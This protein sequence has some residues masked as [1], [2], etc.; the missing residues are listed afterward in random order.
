MIRIQ[1]FIDGKFVDA[2]EGKTLSFI[3]PAKGEIIGQCPA[4]QSTD[5]EKAIA[6]AEHANETWAGLDQRARSEF[7]YAIA[8]EIEK[9]KEE[10]GKIYKA[11]QVKLSNEYQKFSESLI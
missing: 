1:N 9:N 10:L 4:S 5:V 11:Y 8:D 3:N 2:E 6:A 7:L